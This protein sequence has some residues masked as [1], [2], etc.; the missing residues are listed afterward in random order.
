MTG[1]TPPRRADARR[2]QS[3]KSGDGAAG[4]SAPW[5]A[6][7]SRR[8]VATW[9]EAAGHGGRRAEGRSWARGSCEIEDGLIKQKQPLTV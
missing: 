7:G 2:G 1:G 5:R 4:N 8:P 6:G 3:G 9:R